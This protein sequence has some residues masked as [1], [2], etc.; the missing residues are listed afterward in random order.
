ML[1]FTGRFVRQI[2]GDSE[3]V[4][5]KRAELEMPMVNF[6]GNSGSFLSKTD[7]IMR[8]VEDQL[9]FSQN[10]ERSGD[11]RARNVH[12]LNDIFRSSDLAFVDNTKNR[13]QIV[14][15]ALGK[16]VVRHYYPLL[17]LF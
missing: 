7:E 3:N 2:R 11:R 4:D 16:V 17:S 14:F 1:H 15:K 5:Q 10:P 9:S 8:A 6:P 13:F 12:S